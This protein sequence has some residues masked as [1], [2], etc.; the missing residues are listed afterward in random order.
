MTQ[1][2]IFDLERVI[3]RHPSA[4]VLSYNYFR[5]RF[6]GKDVAAR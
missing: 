3:K 2:C 1:R 6:K 4:W 5:N